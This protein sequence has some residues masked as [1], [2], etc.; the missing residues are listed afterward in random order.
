MTKNLSFVWKRAGTSW[1]ADLLE[2]S[3]SEKE[4]YAKSVVMSDLLEPG[5]E[6]VFRKLRKDFD[7]QGVVRTEQEIRTAMADMRG[8]AKGQIAGGI[9]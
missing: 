4:A 8:E 3:G 1:A 2:L 7:D 5:E 9:N 6:D